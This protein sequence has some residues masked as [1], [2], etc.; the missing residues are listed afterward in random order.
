MHQS[1]ASPDEESQ[2]VSKDS[3]L[4]VAACL[5]NYS[6]L[7]SSSKSTKASIDRSYNQSAS[8]ATRSQA[9]TMKAS[10]SLTLSKKIKGIKATRQ[11]KR[12]LYNFI[13]LFLFTY[14]SHTRF[15]RIPVYI[16]EFSV[17]VILV[18][19]TYR[20]YTRTAI[21]QPHTRI[22]LHIPAVYRSV[23]TPF[24]FFAV[25]RHFLGEFG[26]ISWIPL[27]I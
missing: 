3:D 19:F 18:T 4:N 12:S 23:K 8:I 6:K 27:H 5:A 16:P 21:Y 26:H 10:K 15:P 9:E 11:K 7:K 25:V 24:L 14:R 22:F 2:H 20:M 17:L 13:Q 1:G